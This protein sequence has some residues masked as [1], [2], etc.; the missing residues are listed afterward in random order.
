MG[1]HQETFSIC[2]YFKLFKQI[3]IITRNNT[4]GQYNKIWINGY[5]HLENMINNR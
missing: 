3:L 5:G 2:G 1:F 4:R